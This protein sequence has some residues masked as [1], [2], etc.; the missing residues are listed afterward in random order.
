MVRRKVKASGRRTHRTHNAGFKARVALAALREDQTLGELCEQYELHPNQITESKKQLLERAPEEP[1][2]PADLALMRQI[3]EL[4]LE[5]PFMGA[6]ML[7]DQLALQGIQAGRRHIRTLMQRMGIEALA[8]QPGT[9]KRNPG[10]TI[11]PYLLRGLAFTRA[12]QV[13]ALDTT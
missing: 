12:N 13:S 8:P 9:R 2:S 10:H 11:Y 3:D 5:Y 7:R 1:V 4:H 6:R